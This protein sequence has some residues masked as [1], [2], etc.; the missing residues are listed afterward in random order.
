MGRHSACS[1]S[2]RLLISSLLTLF[3]ASSIFSFSKAT[4]SPAYAGEEGAKLGSPF[5]GRMETAYLRGHISGSF[6][7]TSQEQQTVNLINQRRLTMGLRALR[8]NNSLAIAARRHSNDVGPKGLC[9]HN[10]T[11]RSSPWDRIDQAGYTGS[12]M[13]EV[14]GCGY[15]SPKG[16]V[17][18]WWGSSHHYTILTD[19][20]ANEI[21]CGWWVGKKGYGWQT[22]DTGH[23]N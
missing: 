3:V 4:I 12:A 17:D 2:L 16:V 20:N 9:Q 22:C 21:G 19:P 10:G 23:S 5:Y 13:G 18:G 11:D 14:V 15:N 7:L 1:A 6:V 8:V